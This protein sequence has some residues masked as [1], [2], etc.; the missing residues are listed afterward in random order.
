MAL[1]LATGRP[2]WVAETGA[3]GPVWPAGGSIF[4]VSDV[5]QLVRLD[6]ATGA[7]IWAVALP[8][9][10]P[11]SQWRVGMDANYG[12]ILAGGRL[13]VVSSDGA[14]RMFDPTDGGLLDQI[15]LGD[16]AAGA[17]ALANGTLYV[18][19]QRGEL[20]AFR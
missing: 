18:V 14:L 13:I 17:T 7:Q 4:L 8:G 10:V 6:A 12:P 15:A 3:M 11:N 1:D 5:N 9:F 20:L 2:L 19:T 16:G